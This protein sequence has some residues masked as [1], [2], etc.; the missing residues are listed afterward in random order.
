MLI[1]ALIFARVSHDSS[2][3]GRSVEEQVADGVKWAEQEGWKVARVIRE[4][5]SASRFSSRRERVEWAE[6]LRLIGGG[7]IGILLT[8]E[9]SRAT[10]DLAGYAELR[11]ACAK[12][13][14]LWG[15]GRKVYDLGTRDDRFRT[16]LD[17]LLAEDEVARTSERI[18][19]A[20]E[21]NAN[22]GRPHGRNLYGYLRNYDPRTRALRS[23]DVDP[24]TA[25]IVQEAYDLAAAGATLYAI[26]KRL[27]GRGVPP[28]NEKRM[29]HRV[30]EGWTP[31]AVKQM[32]ST[33]GY[34]GLRQFRGEVIGAADW[35]PLVSIEHWTAVQLVLRK[36]ARPREERP[37][38]RYLL[39]GIARCGVCGGVMRSGRTTKRRGESEVVR[40]LSYNCETL[41]TTISMKHLDLIVEEQVVARLSQPGF[42]DTFP[43]TGGVV[44]ED[45]RRLLE[46]IDDLNDWLERVRVLALASKLPDML[47]AQERLVQPQI[48]ENLRHLRALT[49]IPVVTN[50]VESGDVAGAWA[51]MDLASKRKVIR[52]VMT[53]RVQ[54]APFRGARG[55]WQAAERTMFEWRART[56]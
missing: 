50:L 49:E 55:I 33:P 30:G 15:Y 35:P 45:R 24:D 41:H 14:V 20:V 42:L 25:P 19:R 16:G 9:S 43:Q 26:A 36:A 1:D 56:S 23:V 53:V 10:R 39:T 12:A 28:R 31:M 2:G 21:A 38:L 46:E 13:G 7:R 44:A 17:A 54:P 5:G 40:Y 6:A 47:L 3:F 22:A 29:P 52:S 32:L 11:D 48:E 4:T 51:V 8:W 34:A 18:R 27:N 37:E